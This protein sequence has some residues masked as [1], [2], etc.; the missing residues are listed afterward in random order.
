MSCVVAAR[1]KVGER[2]SEYVMGC[3]TG[4]DMHEGDTVEFAVEPQMRL[5]EWGINRTGK[6]IPRGGVVLAKRYGNEDLDS[7]FCYTALAHPH[8]R[9]VVVTE[10]IQPDAVGR[11][12]AGPFSSALLC[13]WADC[14][15]CQEPAGRWIGGTANGDSWLC[16]P[17]GVVWHA[18]KITSWVACGMPSIDRDGHQLTLPSR[19]GF[20]PELCRALGSAMTR[21]RYGP[22]VARLPGALPSR[23]A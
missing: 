21:T 4:L 5:L 15:L 17:C 1:Q 9:F 10:D 3:D 18:A 16:F 23:H 12:T 6:L 11:I 20:T 22:L 19:D 14:P 8:C 2:R 7:L 13:N